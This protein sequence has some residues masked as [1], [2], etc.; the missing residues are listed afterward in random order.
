ML[1]ERYEKTEA[2]RAEIKT[3][4]LVQ[5]RVAR[6]LL[7]VI[8]GSRTGGEWLGLVQGATPA[9]LELLLQQGLI[10][11]AVGSAA[12]ASRS[13]HGP[14]T[15]AFAGPSTLAPGSRAMLTR[16]PGAP[17]STLGYAEL[18]AALSAFAK[19]QGLLK[20]YK[21]QLEVEQCQDLAQLQVL[22]LDV[23]DR[24]RASKGDAVAHD[25]RATL[26]FH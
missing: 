13:T 3:R 15:S 17:T 8:D 26:G 9:D 22:A 21:L 7:L 16:P 10:G 11:G 24:L 4:A 25:L 1:E 12:V 5:A 23:V 2:G 18:Y 6:N 14:S 19:Q 20:G